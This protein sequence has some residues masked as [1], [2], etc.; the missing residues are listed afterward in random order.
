[1]LIRKAECLSGVDLTVCNGVKPFLVTETTLRPP[2][3]I[4]VSG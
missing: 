1:M 2:R 4:L 3:P